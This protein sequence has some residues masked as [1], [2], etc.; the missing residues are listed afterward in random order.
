MGKL[1]N[2]VYWLYTADILPC[3]NGI[4]L[5]IPLYVTFIC[6]YPVKVTI[7]IYESPLESPWG[8]G[9]IQGKTDR[10]AHGCACVPVCVGMREYP[11]FVESAYIYNT[12]QSIWLYV[13]HYSKKSIYYNNKYH[14]RGPETSWFLAPFSMG[15]GLLIGLCNVWCKKK[16]I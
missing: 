14:I 9:N 15:E 7:D 2:Y 5:Y 8:P 1:W 11:F 4:E 13:R 16:C 12:S 6:A 10:S 3:Y